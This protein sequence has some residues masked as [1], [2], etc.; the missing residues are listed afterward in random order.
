MYWQLA[1][2][3]TVVVVWLISLSQITNVAIPLRWLSVLLFVIII[4]E[5]LSNYLHSQH[6]NNQWLYHLYNPVEYL[7]L[8][9]LYRQSA[10][11]QVTKQ[12]IGLSA[13]AYVGFCLVNLLVWQSVTVSPSNAYRV[14]WLFVIILILNYF[15]ELYRNNSLIV[16][17]KEY[18][19]WISVGNFFFYAGTFFLMSLIDEV[20]KRDLSLARQL[21]HINT[22]LNI[23]MYTFWGIAFLCNRMFKTSR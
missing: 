9:Y 23:V 3:G 22:I 14:E 18:L 16:I 1:Y 2:I 19:F 15:Y 8:A 12:W 17:R 21:Y 6:W 5:S 10:H 11:A 7:F 13:I 4:T 20:Q